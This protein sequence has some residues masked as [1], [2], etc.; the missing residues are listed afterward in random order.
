MKNGNIIEGNVRALYQLSLDSYKTIVRWLV[1]DT[2]KIK[3][4]SI[5]FVPIPALADQFTQ[6]ILDVH[7]RE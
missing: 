3:I 5:F 1:K 6:W 4:E 7:V 2:S